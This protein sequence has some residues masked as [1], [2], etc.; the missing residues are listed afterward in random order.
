MS[1][2]IG[3]ATLAKGIR[4]NGMIHDAQEIAARLEWLADS[5]EGKKT[6]ESYDQEWATW[7]SEEVIEDLAKKAEKLAKRLN[8]FRSY[9]RV[10]ANR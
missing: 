4:E 10:G 6:P 1:D 3:D 7:H 8:H 2:Y 9:T 5:L